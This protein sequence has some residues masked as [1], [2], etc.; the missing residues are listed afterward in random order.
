MRATLEPLS[1]LVAMPRNPKA[2]N[3][4]EI[5]Q[6]YDR[7]GFVHR[8]VINEV[9][10]HIVAGHGRVEAL[11]QRKVLN[12]G[13]PKGV[14]E[15]PDDWYVPADWVKV[16]QEEEEA[17]AIALNKIGEGEW[18]EDKTLQI[19]ADLAAQDNLEGT[20]FD[21]DDVDQMLKKLTPVDVKEVLDEYEEE[22]AKWKWLR[23]KLRTETRDLYYDIKRK[24]KNTFKSDD[25]LMEFILD[26][27]T[28]ELL[29]N[30]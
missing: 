21:G 26:L 29:E 2:H 13:L 22:Q 14:V 7:F 12:L 6:S 16:P 8:I 4:G 19:L 23:I 9:T 30:L 15:K 10:G 1:K 25:E 24:T 20:G 3:I 17:L 11:R 27:V 28:D 5:H 18:E